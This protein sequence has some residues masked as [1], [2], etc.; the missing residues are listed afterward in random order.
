M[1][2][3]EYTRANDSPELRLLDLQEK[4]GQEPH[5][6]PNVFSYF[7]PGYAAPGHIKAASIKSPEAMVLTAPKVTRFLNGKQMVIGAFLYRHLFRP[8]MIIHHEIC[9]QDC[10]L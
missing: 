7:Q 1:R 5:Q 9:S 2:A 8:F 6:M 10:F 4:I 3:L